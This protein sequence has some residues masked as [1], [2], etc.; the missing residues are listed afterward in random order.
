M[1]VEKKR[2][3]LV[4]NIQEKSKVINLRMKIL[5][6]TE[7]SML[8]K[9][10]TFTAS[11]RTLTR[12]KLNI[13]FRNSAE[14][15]SVISSNLYQRLISLNPNSRLPKEGS[16]HVPVDSPNTVGKGCNEMRKIYSP[17]CIL[18]LL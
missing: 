2:Q 7:I 17:R 1:S 4:Q 6:E 12:L 16:I 10:R 18:P 9:A 13:L 5:S 3:I 14:W 8:A 15:L 11:L